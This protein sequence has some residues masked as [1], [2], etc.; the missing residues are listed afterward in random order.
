M[1]IEWHLENVIEGDENEVV[2]EIGWFGDILFRMIDW[3]LVR[4]VLCLS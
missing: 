2:N 1:R 3:R 4:M